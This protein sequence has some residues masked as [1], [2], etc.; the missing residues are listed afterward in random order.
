MGFYKDGF[1]IQADLVLAPAPAK[2][3]PP[4]VHNQVVDWLW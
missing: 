1:D 4:S 3:P 2:I